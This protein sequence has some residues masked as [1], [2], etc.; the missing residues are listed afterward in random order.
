[1]SGMLDGDR[2]GV[3]GGGV[4]VGVVTLL[5]L[6]VKDELDIETESS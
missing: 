6:S 5:V 2:G 3:S 1:M 4:G